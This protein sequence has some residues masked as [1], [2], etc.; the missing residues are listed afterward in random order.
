MTA[1]RCRRCLPSASLYSYGDDPLAA[2]VPY[3]GRVLFPYLLD[4][5]GTASPYHG[6]LTSLSLKKTTTKD[7]ARYRLLPHPHH[8]PTPLFSLSH[9]GGRAGAGPPPSSCTSPPGYAFTR[10][11]PG[12]TPLTLSQ[13]VGHAGDYTI[14]PGSGRDFV[15]HPLHTP[16]PHAHASTTLEVHPV[17]PLRRDVLPLVPGRGC[18][19][20][21]PLPPATPL[22]R[23]G[24][25]KCR[26]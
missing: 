18:S 14:A 23:S 3:R 17:G 10:V 15:S 9:E 8:P 16:L 13:G 12:V 2:G 11:L 20:S 7:P 4:L 19:R 21:Q 1:T 6:T 22:V 26:P 25:P 24:R 5:T